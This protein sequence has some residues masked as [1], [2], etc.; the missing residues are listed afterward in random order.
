M[1]NI[2][3]IIFPV[4]VVFMFIAANAFA[5][6]QEPQKVSFKTG[7]KVIAA[8]A[9]PNWG[10]AKVDSIKGGNITV[11]YSDGGLGS[12]QPREIA[13]HPDILY[14]GGSYPCFQPGDR[15]IAK[16]HGDIWRTAT[17]TKVDGDKF[18]VRFYD[19]STKTLKGNEIVRRP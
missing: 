18:E 14:Q 15:V 12:L 13:V 7:M 9:G 1:K 2:K 4:F 16:S 10:A 8:I 5:E 6:C 3:K 17:V 11:K 19:K